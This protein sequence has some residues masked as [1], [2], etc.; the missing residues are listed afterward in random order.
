MDFNMQSLF[1]FSGQRF[2]QRRRGKKVHGNTF[3]TGSVSMGGE[4]HEYLLT[5]EFVK[6]YFDGGSRVLYQEWRGFCPGSDFKAAVDYIFNFMTEKNIYK[7]VC[8]VRQQRVVP[9]SCQKYVE[10]KVLSYI[11]NYGSFYTAFVALEKTA[12]GICARLYDIHITQKL[13]YKVNRFFDSVSEAETWL[14]GK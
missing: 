6:I 8:D 12:G 14:S 7:T 11:K 5:N 2:F 13:N 9:P 3:N 10:E 1:S 4:E